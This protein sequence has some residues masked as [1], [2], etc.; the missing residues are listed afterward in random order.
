MLRLSKRGLSHRGFTL[1]E[2]LVV[3]AIIAVLIALLLP[4]VQQAREAARRTQCRNNL[5]Q[6]GLALHNYENVFNIFPNNTQFYGPNLLPDGGG[7][8]WGG[9]SV[10]VKLL[11]YV[12]QAPLYS[13]INFALPDIIDQVI[14]GKRLLAYQP[15]GFLCP[16]DTPPAF[17]TGTTNYA[18]SCGSQNLIGAGCP[19]YEVGAFGPNGSDNYSIG[20]GSV[21]RL[22]FLSGIFALMGPAAAIRDITDGTS[23]TIAFGEVRPGCNFYMSNTTPPND[24]GNGVPQLDHPFGWADT[25]HMYFNTTVPINFQTCPGE[26]LGTKNGSGGCNDWSN[27]ATPFGFKS[28]HVGG[29]HFLLCDGSVRFISQNIDYLTYQKLG[30]RHDGQTIGEF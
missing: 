4:A 17:S 15:P 22:E 10:F 13:G 14:N 19:Q 3:I 7:W 1:I 18:P 24:Y 20:P 5:K 16:S 30:D 26:G 25:A 23:N 11:P 6:I 21:A 2:L 9:G 28:R 8:Y 12:D 27:F 29:G